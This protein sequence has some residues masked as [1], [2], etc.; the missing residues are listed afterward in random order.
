MTTKKPKAGEGVA[1]PVPAPSGIDP[2]TWATIQQAGSAAAVR[3][4]ELIEGPGWRSLKASDKAALIRLAFDRAY[5]PPVQRQATLTLSGSVSDAVA[6]S[7][8]RLS[9]ADLPETGR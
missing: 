3:L 5:G 6:D 2:E 7:L 8:A 4:L 9:A 1:K